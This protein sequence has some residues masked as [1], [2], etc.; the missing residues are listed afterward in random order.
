MPTALAPETID[1]IERHFDQMIGQ[2]RAKILR[3]A[4]WRRP[5]LTSDDLLMAHDYPEL[6]AW[7]D[8]QFEDGILAGLIQAQVSLRAAFFRPGASGGGAG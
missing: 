3:M 1:A 5:N 4:R 6:M 7:A 2:Q 8:Y